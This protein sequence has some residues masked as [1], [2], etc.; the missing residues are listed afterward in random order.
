MIPSSRQQVARFKEYL[1]TERR[2]SPHTQTG[3][4]RDLASLAEYCSTCGIERWKD[5]DTPRARNFIAH[6]HKSGLSGRSIQR[7]LSAARTFYNYL[8]REQVVTTN[9]FLGLRPPKQNKRLPDALSTD[10]V[11]LLVSVKAREPLALRDR[12]IMELFYSSGLRLSEL[13]NLDLAHLDRRQ[14]L[15]R[16]RG[17]GGKSR[18]VPVGR[19]AL[20]ALEEWMGQRAEIAAEQEPALFVTRNGRRMSGRAVQY[21]IKYWG[22]RQGLD[23]SVHPHMLRHSFASHLLESSG[24]LRAVQEL[25]GHANISTTQVYTHLDFQHLSKVYDR[26]HP[27]AKKKA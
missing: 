24:E 23:V 26:A 2:V 3:Y 10:Q 21:R 8:A 18:E 9:P 19:L 6:M 1:C 15:V 13:V 5:L 12:A 7:A 27:R 25:L 4:R 22:R 11:A 14:A 16:V 20:R 17:K